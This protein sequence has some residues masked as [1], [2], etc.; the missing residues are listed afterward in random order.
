MN[1]QSRHTGLWL[2]AGI[3]L[4]AAVSIV[5]VSSWLPVK[6]TGVEAKI[7]SQSSRKP[8]ESKSQEI[9]SNLPTLA[10]FSPAWDRRLR[11]VQEVVAPPPPPTKRAAPPPPANPFTAKLTGLIIEDNHS[12]A[13]F[14]T[15]TG[16][17]QFVSLGQMI[18]DAKV[19]EIQPKQVILHRNGQSLTL[20]ITET[21]ETSR[22]SRPAPRTRAPI[23]NRRRPTR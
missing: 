6:I 9:T 2:L 3:C 4:I 13:L 18:E 23:Y 7:T 5:G 21:P 14:T 15:Q 8:V 16:D 10:S 11:P 20:E 17:I 22:S 1:K 12:M 19:V